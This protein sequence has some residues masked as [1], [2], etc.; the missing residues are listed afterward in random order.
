LLLDLNLA[1]EAHR[2]HLVETL[3]DYA[4][5]GVDGS[6]TMSSG[7]NSSRRQSFTNSI[8]EYLTSLTPSTIGWPRT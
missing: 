3:T 2:A 5:D 8:V 7:S 4:V 1:T 6:L